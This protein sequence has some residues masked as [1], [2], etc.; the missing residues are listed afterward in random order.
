MVLM[1]TNNPYDSLFHNDPPRAFGANLPPMPEQGSHPENKL[2]SLD[3]VLAKNARFQQKAVAFSAMLSNL[4]IVDHKVPNEVLTLFVDMGRAHDQGSLAGERACHELLVKKFRLIIEPMRELAGLHLEAVQQFNSDIDDNYFSV[5]KTDSEVRSEKDEAVDGLL[6]QRQVLAEAAD[7][8]QI[9]EDAL[10]ACERRMKRYVN[11]GGI[12][13]ISNSELSILASNRE[14]LTSGM[15]HQFDFG[16]F[17]ANLLDKAAFA[18]GFYQK[19]TSGQYLQRLVHA[20]K[21]K[22]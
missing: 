19:E 1:P 17:D 16:F 4:R 6:L 10:Q 13:N 22:K 2:E 15:E 7:N 5:E 18:L 3:E 9:L 14:R 8:L 12:N 20:F 11:A 21:N